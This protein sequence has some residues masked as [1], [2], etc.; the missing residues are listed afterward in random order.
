M[1]YLL[2]F[3]CRIVDY[4]HVFVAFHSVRERGGREEERE[5]LS[6][7]IDDSVCDIIMYLL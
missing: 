2:L 1:F 4:I 6:Q 5:L 3:Y 7:L